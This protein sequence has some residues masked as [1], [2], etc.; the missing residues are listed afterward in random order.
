[1]GLVEW[2]TDRNAP[3]G[4][5]EC[6]WTRR[7][8]DCEVASVLAGAYAGGGQLLCGDLVA[9][10]GGCERGNDKEL[11]PQLR[12]LPPDAREE[13]FVGDGDTEVD[14]AGSQ[15]RWFAPGNHVAGDEREVD[16]AL[17]E[18]SRR[19]TF[20]EW[21]SDLLVVALELTDRVDR[22]RG[23]VELSSTLGTIEAFDEPDDEHAVKPPSEAT[24][25]LLLTGR[26]L[27]FDDRALRPDGNVDVRP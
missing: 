27:A 16:H 4:A 9:G 3:V 15:D 1:M 23:I 21:H 22:D 18:P 19:H 8:D 25:Q 10:I 11:G 24:Q 20:A 14:A 7:A 6:G 17:H 13:V 2:C 12:R 26:H 5:D